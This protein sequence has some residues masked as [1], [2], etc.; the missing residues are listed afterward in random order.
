MDLHQTEIP[1]DPSLTSKLFFHRILPTH[2]HHVVRLTYPPRPQQTLKLDRCSA[3]RGCCMRVG[4]GDS[5]RPTTM[6]LPILK[7]SIAWIK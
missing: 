5:S 4:R 1:L 2:T 3:V 6:E 7:V